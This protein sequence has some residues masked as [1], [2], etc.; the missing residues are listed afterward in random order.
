MKS[1]PAQQLILKSLK[2]KSV[3][4]KDIYNKTLSAFEDLKS[5]LQ[6]LEVELREKISKI[7]GEITV[8]YKDRGK[9][10]AELKV[11]DDA[12]IFWMHTD[13]FSFDHEHAMWKTSYVQEDGSRAHCGM[14][15]I[16]NFLT[17]S[18]KYNRINDVGYLIARLFLN[19]DMHY[20]VEG[21]RQLGFL[22][23]DFDHTIL[24]RK[25]LKAV[26]ESAILYSL[27]FDLFTPAYDDMKQLS[28]SEIIEAANNIKITTGKRLGFR[29]QADDDGID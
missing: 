2:E 21:K 9:F 13:I 20:F 6:E 24:D 27:D 8:T 7:D 5:I 17:D 23:N 4:K 10:E 29:F 28:V 19:K 14:I 11:A 18:F 22:Y 3:V 25:E 26:I 15:C 16:Y 1:K 12:L